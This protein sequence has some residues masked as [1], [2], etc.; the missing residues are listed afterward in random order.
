M[1]PTTPATGPDVQQLL[2][3][4]HLRQGWGILLLFV[5]LGVVLETL[6]AFKASFYNRADQETW[7]LMWRLAHGHGTLLGLLHLAFSFSLSHLPERHFPQPARLMSFCLT[8]AS[9]AI[10]GGFFLGGL[11]SN[12]G[13][14]GIAI[15]L[16]PMGAVPLLAALSLLFFKLKSS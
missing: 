15:V 14:P 7:R 4:R 2:I 11:G 16:V 13:D 8:A 6:L 3:R 12:E 10:P 5:V 1:N 9:L